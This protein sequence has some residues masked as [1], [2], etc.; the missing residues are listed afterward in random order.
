MGYSLLDYSLLDTYSCYYLSRP[1]F[2]CRSMNETS[3][4]L[5]TAHI[6]FVHLHQSTRFWK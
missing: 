5:V 6:S 2:L 1:R 3:R 4:P